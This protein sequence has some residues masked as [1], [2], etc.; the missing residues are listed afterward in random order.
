MT[1]KLTICSSGPMLKQIFASNQQGRCDGTYWATRRRRCD[2]WWLCRCNGNL[3]KNMK[4][5]IRC[6]SVEPIM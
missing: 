5:N 6:Q 4:Q 1:R 3:V 2:C